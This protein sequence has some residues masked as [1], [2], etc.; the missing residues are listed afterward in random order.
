MRRVSSSPLIQDTFDARAGMSMPYRQL[1]VV[2]L[3]R[4]DPRSYR[5]PSCPDIPAARAENLILQRQWSIAD[6][7]W[8]R[9]AT[10]DPVERSQ[11]GNAPEDE[12]R[13]RQIIDTRGRNGLEAQFASDP[14]KTIP[15]GWLARF[16][17]RDLRNHLHSGDASGERAETNATGTV[18]RLD[19]YSSIPPHVLARF[20]EDLR[21]PSAQLPIGAW[22]TIISSSTGSHVAASRTSPPVQMVV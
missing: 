13:D 3:P 22:M 14:T 15:C 4:R 20:N 10:I 12:H 1:E 6:R 5:W 17:V 8:L 2:A 7:L 18:S 19:D 9:P 16:S 11:A 21:G